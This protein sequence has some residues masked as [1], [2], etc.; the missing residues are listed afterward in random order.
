MRWSRDPA[1]FRDPSGFVFTN[2]GVVYRHVDASFASH[3]RQ[4]IDS[5][6][7]GD[8]VRDGLMVAHDE[9]DDPRMDGDS[10]AYAVLA[11]THIP[12]ISHPYEWCFGQYKAAALLTLDLQRRAVERGMILRDAS[13]YN[14]QFSAGRPIFI[15]TLSFGS[16]VEG[17]PW[18]AY[19]QFCEQFLT[20]LAL[21]A[22]VDPSLG[23]LMR[24]HI[25]GIPLRVGA[26]LLPLSSH[27]RAGLLTH[28]HLHLRS[29]ASSLEQHAGSPARPGARRFGKTA[30]LGLVD[31][32]MRTVQGLSWK[33]PATVWSTYADHCN[34]STTAQ[35]HKRQLVAEWFALLRA[36]STL[37]MV[38]DFGANVGTY[39]RIA[40]DHAG[41]VVSFDLEHA[42][43]ERHYRDCVNREEPRVL[44]LV[45]D[46]R[47]P[48]AA[49]GW[50]H[51]ERRSLTDRGPADAV[52]ALA[53]VHH[54][55]IGGNVP[56]PAIATFFR[57]VSRYLIVEFV[58]KE[59]SQIGRMLALR[60]DNFPGYSLA[61]FEKAFTPHFEI[62]RTARIND[63]VRT[64]YL[65]QRR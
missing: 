51:A 26:Q 47:N 14:V 46:L 8:L 54:L 64:M 4:L 6:L 57:D 17:Q 25:D 39:S 13:A 34:Y 58:P 60:E 35:E 1:S 41:L 62:L 31:S 12:F 48:S 22:L 15:D 3:Y 30:M 23:Q 9:V 18:L 16:L 11:P 43:V 42:A 7:Y 55:A 53:L 61:E 65:M 24:V 27:L 44:P 56:L 49:T 52:L 45:Q 2:N 33:P 40:A 63:T 19:R 10:Q 32:L 59:D 20:P 29:T 50:H 37:E 36:R 5:G 21:M 38:W 28:V